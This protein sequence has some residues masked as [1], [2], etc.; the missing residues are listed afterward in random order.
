MTWSK[1]ASGSPAEVQHQA[2]KWPEGATGKEGAQIAAAESAVDRYTREFPDVVEK[3]ETAEGVK[4][5]PTKRANLSVSASGHA[6]ENGG[7]EVRL[8]FSVSP[9]T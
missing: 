9:A 4:D 5:G 3:V 1:S 7:G 6:D 2:R 8:S